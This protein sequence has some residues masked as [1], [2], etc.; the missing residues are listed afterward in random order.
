MNK[1]TMM[2]TGSTALIAMLGVT[3]L[4]GVN[5]SVPADSQLAPTGQHS[6]HDPAGTGHHSSEGSTPANGSSDVPAVEIVD[7][8][9]VLQLSA[10][11][12]ST[13]TP[14]TVTPSGI[15][16][17]PTTIVRDSAGKLVLNN[18]V[19]KRLEKPAPG[20]SGGA[21]GQEIRVTPLP[22]V[23][24][25]GDKPG[26]GNGNGNGKA[27]SLGDALAKP[28]GIAAG[29]VGPVGDGVNKGTT[30]QAPGLL[31]RV[32]KRGEQDAGVNDAART[33]GCAPGYG[34][35]RSCLPVAPPSAAQQPGNGPK[36]RWTCEELLTL[37]PQGIPLQVRGTD[38]L[39]L[40]EDGN[41]IACA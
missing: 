4:I 36:V 38:P 37:F 12:P 19:G 30:K 17:G 18:V 13:V 20:N 2:T 5:S 6:T 41:G 39:R 10:V 24:S 21:P 7:Q 35:G 3:A 28:H 14:A 22:A 33:G 8:T 25:I 40:D 32:L 23:P 31:G 9:G 16:P 1:R 29:G 26:N 15:T 27:Q 34:D 11:T